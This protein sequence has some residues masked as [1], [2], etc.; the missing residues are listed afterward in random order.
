MIRDDI[1]AVLERVPTWPE[2]RQ[3]ELARIAL[4][5]EAQH[6]AFEPE[7]AAT[8]A[9]IAEGLAQARR[10]EFAPAEEVEAVLKRPWR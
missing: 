3:A 1:K 8:R 5:L 6:A 7:D 2:G 9:A 4:Q 10:G